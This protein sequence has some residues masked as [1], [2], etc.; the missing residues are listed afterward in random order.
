M[1]QLHRCGEVLPKRAV[2][3]RLQHELVPGFSRDYRLQSG[4]PLPE[5]RA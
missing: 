5:A 2:T 1:L 4:A 3:V